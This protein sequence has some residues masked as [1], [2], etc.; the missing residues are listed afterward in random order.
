MP[1]CALQFG[2]HLRLVGSSPELGAWS[3][4]AA[5]KLAWSTGNHWSAQVALPPGQHFFKLVVV[6]GD[7]RQQWEDGQNRELA[8]QASD[9]RAVCRFGNTTATTLDQ[10]TPAI[11]RVMR[12]FDAAR[13]GARVFTYE[14]R[15]CPLRVHPPAGCGR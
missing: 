9:L 12:A 10:L 14:I 2:E 13:L 15:P 6:R 5:P 1:D 4:E 8:V 3:T 7:G 11:A